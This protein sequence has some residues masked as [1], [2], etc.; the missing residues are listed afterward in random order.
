VKLQA[1]ACVYVFCCALTLPQDGFSQAT[2]SIT[3]VTNAALPALALPPKSA[4]LAPRSIATIFG[5]QLADST[6]S[7]IPPWPEALGGTEV[8]LAEDSCYDSS[9]EFIADLLYVSPTQINFVVPDVDTTKLWSTRVILIRDGVRFDDPS[10]MLGGPGRI[11]IDALYNYNQAIVFGVG[12]ECLFSFSLTDPSACGLS[13]SPG[14]HRALLGAVTNALSGELFTTSNPVQQGE[15]ITIW[16]TSI[17][18]MSRDAKTGLLQYA[19]PFSIG[20]GVAQSGNDLPSTVAIGM[21]GEFGKFQTAPALWVGESPEF[22]GLDQVNVSFP[23]CTSTT[24]AATEKRYDAFLTYTSIETGATVRVYL[25]FLVRPGDPDCQWLKTTTATITSSINPSTVGQSVT[26]TATVAPAATTGTVSFF[27]GSSMLGSGTLSGGNATF[28]TSSL[29][30]GN[31]SINA[32][33]AG[34]SNYAGSSATRTQT[35]KA[36]T[37]T[38][39]AS[40]LNP[41]NSDQ[42]VTLTVTILPS[43]ATGTVTFFDGISTLGSGALSNGKVTFSSFNLGAGNHSITATYGGDSNYGGSSGTLTQVV[44]LNTAITLTSS[45]SPATFGQSLTFTAVVSCCIATGTVTFLDAN[46][47]LGSGTLVYLP[48]NGIITA[49]LVTSSLSVGSH[50]IRASY[51][52]DTNDNGSTSAVMTQTIWTISLTSSPNPSLSGQFVTLTACG[53]PSG[54]VGTLAFL[55]GTAVIA[56]DSILSVPCTSLGAI[57]SLS[58]GTHSITARYSDNNG[59]STAATLTQIVN[60][61]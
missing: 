26:F 20:F 54:T 59:G 33:Y 9:C 38:T 15:L 18:G 2:P 37:T 25:P 57:N 6:F 14:G 1:A 12:Y 47:T 41:S 16:V 24:T 42:S 11:T 8:H 35:V 50:S 31:H 28:S 10:R 4:I 19:Y 48:Q 23:L 34:D 61:P 36:S 49:T 40:S 13:W 51:G 22:V 60:K 17:P 39:L 53:I 3:N 30:T 21:E 29:G 52:G 5:T 32:T 55:D 27:D 56:T 46:S 44:H 7:A 43:S 58:A 45:A